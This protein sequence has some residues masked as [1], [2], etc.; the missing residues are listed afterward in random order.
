[1]YKLHKNRHSVSSLFC[2]KDLVFRTEQ[3][4]QSK[5]GRNDGKEKSPQTLVF[6]SFLAD[7]VGF[8]PTV[9]LP[10]HLISSQGRYNHFDTCPFMFTGVSAPSNG[11][12][13]AWLWTELPDRTTNYSIIRTHEKCLKSRACG[14]PKRPLR[15]TISSQGRYNHFDTCAYL[16][17]RDRQ[18]VCL[19]RGYYSRY[20][21]KMQA[22]E[23]RFADIFVKRG[24]VCS[25]KN[26]MAVFSQK[27]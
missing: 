7:R 12:N 13:A 11:K 3:L 24:T 4:H 17:L 9:P 15:Q 23:L 14:Y 18:D 22:Q 2:P 10:V 6:T 5:N 26:S 19:L 25:V 1:M 27:G 21:G 8:E 20:C 16:E